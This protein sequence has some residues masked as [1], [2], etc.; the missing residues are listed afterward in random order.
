LSET[1]EK[2]RADGLITKNRP[3]IIKPAATNTNTIEDAELQTN[4]TIINL[5][6]LGEEP[7]SQQQKSDTEPFQPM[8][9][10]RI[11]QLYAVCF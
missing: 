8:R 10:I 3:N 4:S 2:I 1:I 7:H 11:T 6:E 9:L 5:D